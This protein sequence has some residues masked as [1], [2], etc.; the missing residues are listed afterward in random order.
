MRLPIL[1]A[2]AAGL[3]VVRPARGRRPAVLRAR[4]LGQAARRPCRPAD[5]DPF[6]GPHLRSLPRRA[7]AV[8]QAAGRTAR[9]APGAGRRRSAAAGARARGGDAGAPASDAARAGAFTDR[10]Y[11]RLRYEIDP[12]WA[13][14]LPRT[15]MIDADGKTTVLPGVAD[16]AQVRAGSMPSPSPVPEE[17]SR[18]SFAALPSPTS[19][20][21]SSPCPRWAQDYKAGRA[22]K[23][24]SPG[25]APPPPPQDRVAASSASPTRARRPTG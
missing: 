11:E 3:V 13:G 22:W 15:V 12:A 20:A 1:L 9:P 14:E 24:A 8:G 21:R 25:R 16:L 18:W 7:A 19:P 5:G 6:L 4:Q 17:Q 10:F 23:S 2:L